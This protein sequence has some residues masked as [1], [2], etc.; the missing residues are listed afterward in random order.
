MTKISIIG[1]G[2][3]G[4]TT[5]LRIAEKGLG[6]I[7]LLDV[8]EGLPQGKALDLLQSS[9]ISGYDLDIVGTN[10][11]GDIEGSDIV[12][13]TAGLARKPGMSRDDLLNKNAEIV[14]DISGKIK[15]YARD[16]KVLMVTNP[17]D[18]MTY[19]AFKTTKFEPERVFGMAGVLDAA[20]FRTFIA[21]ELG[22]SVKVVHTMVLGSHGDTMVPLPGYTTVD[23]IP[24]TQLMS[25]EKMEKLIERTRNG[26]AEIVKYLKDGSA[27]YAPS[28]AVVEM[29]EAV[30]RDM[31]SVLSCSAY[32]RGEYGVNDIYI[33]VPV[34]LGKGGVEEIIGL[35]LNMAER[36]AF[37]R[38]AE[39]VRE[40]I[41]GH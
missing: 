7:V 24:I 40:M 3:V 16:S 34:K 30:V 33:G 12:V 25:E 27:F 22:V 1:A 9:P 21:R 28:A 38:S 18:V 41:P 20:R 2:Q 26:G 35:E 17:L 8:I 19:V 15:K 5:A 32:L 37:M 13:V 23:G 29:I 14:K 10:N 36:E 11:Y 31:K 6:D 4:S 39:S